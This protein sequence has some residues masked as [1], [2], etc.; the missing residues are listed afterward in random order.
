VLV[1]QVRAWFE[2]IRTTGNRAVHEYYANVRAALQAVETC[3]RLGDWL[4]RSL[5]QSD[6]THRVF[7]APA[8]PSAAP[9]PET[10][11][12]AQE[13]E[14]L[15]SELD[16]YRRKLEEAR[17]RYDGKQSRLEREQAA[18]EQAEAELARAEAERAAL[19]D[20]IAELSDK[21]T[22]LTAPALETRS[23][24][25][26][27]DG[28][29]QRDE[30]IA[31]AQKAARPPMSEAQVRAE[32]DRILER[33]GWVVQDDSGKNLFAGK[34]VAVRE[35][36]TA[37]GRADYLLYVDQRLVGV[38]EA[39]REG[40]DLEG[41]MQ[42]AAR[43]A[44]GLTRSQQLSAWR[45]SLPFRYVA[46]GNTV[47][48][49]NALDPSPRT[50]EVFA[51]HQPETIARWIDEAACPDA[52]PAADLPRP[53]PPAPGPDQGDHRPGALPCQGRPARPDPD[54]DRRRQDVHGGQ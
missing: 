15:R 19:H 25:R 6:T 30:F 9:A 53:G 4:H 20:V 17:L 21:I 28:A 37:V 41:A 11:A 18:R 42:Q 32:L 52:P 38:I 5:D 26:P 33:A 8:H 46:D 2:A 47:R 13:L 22:E 39:K 45:A 10:V 54:G 48:F 51:V 40:A 49:H 1:P 50:R 43:Y 27:L 3:F 29:S 14:Q 12:D 35:V 36:S 31:Y 44:T 23:T 24:A 7:L 34:G 16:A